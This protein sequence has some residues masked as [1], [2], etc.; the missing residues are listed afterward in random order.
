MG[1]ACRRGPGRP[2]VVFFFFQ[3]EDGIRDI[4]VTGVQTCALPIVK[5]ELVEEP[6]DWPWSSFR[7]Y[8]SGAEG[9]VEIESQWTARKRERMGVMPQ[10]VVQSQILRPV[11]AKDAVT[12]TGQPR[13][14]K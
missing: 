9:V 3:A 4:G 7:H 13:V 14:L 11:T 5:R 6:Q 12:R 1:R 2:L 8:L 10:I